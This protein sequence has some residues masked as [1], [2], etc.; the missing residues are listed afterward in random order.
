MKDVEK[1]IKERQAGQEVQDVFEERKEKE[2]L[3]QVIDEPEEGVE[4]KAQVDGFEV[5]VGQA[6]TGSIPSSAPV[7][8]VVPSIKA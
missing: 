7:E 5:G 4:E 1:K 2:D 6:E 8:N 3:G